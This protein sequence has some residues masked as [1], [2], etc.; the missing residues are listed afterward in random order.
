MAA[1]KTLQI[2]F[3]FQ[4]DVVFFPTAN[5]VQTCFTHWIGCV[6]GRIALPWPELIRLRV[7]L[8]SQYGCDSD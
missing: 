4:P 3:L 7:L 5:M 1:V 2:H 8:N 6:T